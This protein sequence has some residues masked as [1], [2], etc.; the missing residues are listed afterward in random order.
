MEM[1]GEI[2]DLAALPT[3]K[4][5]FYPWSKRMCEPHTPSRHIGKDKNPK[6]AFPFRKSN[7]NSSTVQPVTYSPYPLHYQFPNRGHS[8]TIFSISCL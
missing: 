7:H 3:V 8:A 1:R 6:I 5:P 2:H 4:E